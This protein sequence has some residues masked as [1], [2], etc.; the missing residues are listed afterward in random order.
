M[1]LVPVHTDLVTFWLFLMNRLISNVFRSLRFRMNS[2]LSWRPTPSSLLP[3][4]LSLLVSPGDDPR[5]RPEALSVAM[6]SAEL[7]RRK[8]LSKE[9]LLSLGLRLSRSKLE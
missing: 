5:P 4:P 3:S 2:P 1:A 9:H 6:V 7:R 8:S